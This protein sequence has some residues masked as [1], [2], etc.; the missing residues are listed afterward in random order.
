MT[1]GTN[2]IDGNLSWQLPLIFQAFA[3]LFVMV[4]V[5]FIPESP[6]WLM[7]QGRESEAIEFL[8]K[9]HG[10]NNRESRI[11]LLEIQEMRE[12]IRQDGID[13]VWWD[14][15]PLFLTHAGRWRMAQVLMISIF[16]QFSGNGLGYFN[17]V[18]FENIGVNTVSQ[19]LGYNLLNSV[20]SAIGALT[21][22]CLT[23]R[24]PRRPVLIYGTMA[25]SFAL[26]IN[27][28]LSAALDNQGE[29]VI[30]SYAQGALASYFMFNII[31]SFTYTPLQGAIPTE[32][33]E[34]TIR[35]KGLAMSGIIV[36]TIGF[37][38]QFATP[39]ALGN[40]QYRYIFIFVGWDLFE[41]KLVM[42]C[43]W[44]C[45]TVLTVDIP[46][47]PHV[48]P[49][50]CRIPRPHAGAARMGLRPAQP[51]QGIAQGRQGRGAGRRQGH[52]EDCGH[53]QRLSGRSALLSP[54]S[55]L[56]PKFPSIL[57]SCLCA[58]SLRH[59]HF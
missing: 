14:Y 11:V 33:L 50:W 15:R 44:F 57:F 27:S 45:G 4:G 48:V 47:S 53:G 46:N 1:F 58:T 10:N 23:D 22:V 31:F 30:L 38:N 6:R 41:G 52:R 9:Y 42:M 56:C 54:H 3:C 51:S 7:T 17:T 16:G 25:C 59:W 26:A 21:A 13:K 37:I 40:I 12:G 43:G 18:I 19:R 32:A 39:I 55:T 24:M 29:N 49:V 8:V 20:L 36:S 2:N 35:A 34:T 28:G 5:F